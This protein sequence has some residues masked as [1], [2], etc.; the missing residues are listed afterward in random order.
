MVIVAGVLLWVHASEAAVVTIH[1]PLASSD[2]ML[3]TINTAGQSV[4]A[5]ELHLTF[6]PTLFSVRSVSDGG[7]VV[8]L[9]IEQPSFSNVSGTI[10]MQGIIP[11]GIT[12]V[13]GTIATIEIVPQ[14]GEATGMMSVATGTVLLNDGQGTPAPLTFVNAQFPLAEVAS[15]SPVG[16]VDTTPPNP[17]TPIVT[18]NPNIFGGQYFLVFSATDE[19]SGIDHYEVLETAASGTIGNVANWQ[20]ATSPYLLKDQT[21]SSDIY[22]RA[23]DRAGNFRVVEIPAAE[24]RATGEARTF[25]P[26]LWM[27]FGIL[28]VVVLI[29]LAAWFKKRKHEI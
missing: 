18:S 4:N 2:E 29:I 25:H 21:L 3:V 10:D 16:P 23:V 27:L 26:S 11:G 28:I 12:T 20:V 1:P 5:I 14:P 17:F 13:S 6:D 9:W 15:S 24:A 22:V 7:S 8:D 19:D